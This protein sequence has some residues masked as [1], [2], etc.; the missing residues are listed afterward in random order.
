MDINFLYYYRLDNG[1]ENFMKL[2]IDGYEYLLM[3]IYRLIGKFF[4]LCV[5]VN[6]CNDFC[7]LIDMDIDILQVL[8]Y[9][10]ILNIVIVD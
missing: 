1:Y 10:N 6:G 9:I 3:Y 5:S 4:L 2:Q 7:F 8:V